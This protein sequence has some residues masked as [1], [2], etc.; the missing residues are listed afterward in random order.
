MTDA[1]TPYFVDLGRSVWHA[2]HDRN[3]GLIAAGVAFYMMFAIFPG[4][5]ATI[6]I[7]GVFADPGAMRDYLEQIRG[8]IPDAAFDVIETQLNALLLANTQTLGWTTAVSLAIA[9][10]SVH[11]GV[12]ALITGL[13]AIHVRGHRPGLLRIAI[14]VVITVA[15]IA[16]FLCALATV[17]LVPIALNFVGLGLVEA[18]VLRFL[19]W[20]VLFVVVFLVLGLFYR[21]GPNME[22]Q[23]HSWVTPGAVLAAL[24]WAGAS[25][26]FSA[27]L[28]NFGSYNKIYG[29]I[30]AVIALMMWLYISAYI[31]LLGAALNAERARIRRR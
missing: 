6:A 5:A 14:S 12:S 11:S 10:Y 22:G 4:M 31:V 17:V 26:A 27:Y 21:W 15:L 24:L 18:L 19:P 20:F 30:G 29:S 16:V 25:M 3:L 13:N 28:A 1:T 9:L 23:R 7:W 8:L 2:I